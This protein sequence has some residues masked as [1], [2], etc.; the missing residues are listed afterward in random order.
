MKEEK[1]EELKETLTLVEVKLHEALSDYESECEQRG[2]T[3][4]HRILA[5]IDI[6]TDIMDDMTDCMILIVKDIEHKDQ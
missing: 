4:E 1:L 6:L 2:H 5:A 3:A